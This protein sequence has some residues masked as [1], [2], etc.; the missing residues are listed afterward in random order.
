MSLSSLLPWFPSGSARDPADRTRRQGPPAK[1][2]PGRRLRLERLEDRTLLSGLSLIAA[3][4]S[5][6]IADINAANLAG[7]ANTITLKKNNYVL[8]AVNNSTDGATGLPVIAASDNLT[9]VGKGAAI[10][11]CMKKG[12]PA[13]RL[14]DVAAGASLTLQNLTLQGGLAVQGG[15]IYNQ[16]AL[17]LN[18]A[19][20]QNNIAQ[21]GGGIYSSG[22]LTLEGGTTIRNNKALGYNTVFD[23]AGGS[24]LGGGLCVSGGTAALTNVTLSSNTAQ[25]GNGGYGYLYTNGGAGGSGLGVR[26][27]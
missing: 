24:A 10:E 27:R 12:T 4:V 2:R 19:I 6:L 8:T 13:F 25:G 9:I 16:G 7:G 26:C 14:F 22:G 11:P 18:G 20:V 15:A 1:R 23:Y 17:T 3:S 21:S 5:D